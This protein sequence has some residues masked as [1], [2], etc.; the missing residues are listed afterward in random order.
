M[1]SASTGDGVDLR[2]PASAS[3]G[4]RSR[5]PPTSG[6]RSD[7]SR[8]APRAPPAARRKLVEPLGRRRLGGVGEARPQAPARVAVEG[9]LA[10]AE[11]RAP[12]RSSSE[13]SM[14][15]LVSVEHAQPGD[16]VRQP[17]GLRPRRPPRP[18]PSSTTR[19][20]A[21]RAHHLAVDRDGGRA[22]A[23]DE[24]SHAGR[25]LRR[26][27]G[28]GS[29][30]SPSRSGRMPAGERQVPA[31]GPP[32]AELLERAAEAEVGVVVGRVALDHGRELA[33]GVAGSGRCGS[34]PARA[35]RGSR[36]CPAR[37]AWPS[38]ARRRPAPNGS[39]SSSERPRWNSA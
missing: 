23:L 12:P 21:D 4:P 26:C 9:E 7:P 3:P 39:P 13:R 38:R 22:D 29:A 17:R 2:P 37:G 30:G 33:R 32:V 18:T 5:A 31:G 14:R 34:R 16:L 36:S 19:P 20:V 11:R 25:A 15:P 28:R 10:D 24:R 6:R 1:R 35:P 27:P 8:P